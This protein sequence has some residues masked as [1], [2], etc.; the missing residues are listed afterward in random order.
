[1]MEARGS[2]TDAQVTS[3]PAQSISNWG[4][5]RAMAVAGGGHVLGS[6]LGRI[7][8]GQ[9]ARVVVRLA[10]ELALV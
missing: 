1:M 8:A 2:K 9:K 6:R 3:E 7:A 5:G 10:V 4:K